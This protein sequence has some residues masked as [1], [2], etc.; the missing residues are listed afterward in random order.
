MKR[1]LLFRDN[2][3]LILVSAED[4]KKG[5]Y[6]RHDN[7]VDPEYEFKVEYVNGAKNGGG[8]YFRLYY[9]YEEYKRLYP[10]RADRYELVANM[11]RYEESEWH[12]RWKTNV[13]GFCNIERTIQ[14]K[15]TRKWKI[16]DAYYPAMKTCIEFQHSYISFHF[17]E[18]T[19]STVRYRCKQFGFMIYPVP[20]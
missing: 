15:E 14:N 17:E 4:V 5:L 12:T 13:A 19:S 7:Y 10:E 1:A 18:K 16:A 9:S 8:P 11:R 3:K 6:D 2:E 20:I